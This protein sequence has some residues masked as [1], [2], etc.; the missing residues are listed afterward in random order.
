M[1]GLQRYKDDKKCSIE[2]PFKDHLSR[3]HII[4]VQLLSHF[5]KELSLIYD[6]MNTLYYDELSQ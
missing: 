1:L 6:F 5:N 3:G 4:V 2:K